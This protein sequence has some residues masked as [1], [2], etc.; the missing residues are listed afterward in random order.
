MKQ[1]SPNWYSIKEAA[2][3]LNVG[4]PTLY[5]W[6]REGR[7]TFRKVGDSTRFLRNDL[8]AM[9]E[10]HPSEK[11]AERVT[12]FCPA[13]HHD[14]LVEGVVQGTGVNYFR[15]AETKFWSFATAN[16]K[17]TAWMCPKCGAIAWFGDVAKLRS[18]RAAG[19]KEPESAESPEPKAPRG[20]SASTESPEAS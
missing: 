2:D 18:L 15:P 9:V 7:I 12:R 4:E 10:V 5:R 20:G 1:Q 3:Y 14:Q 16:V 11:D 6:M 17:T 19:K 13:C 8:D